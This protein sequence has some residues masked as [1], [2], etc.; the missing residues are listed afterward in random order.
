VIFLEVAEEDQTT[1]ELRDLLAK[2]GVKV[3]GSKLEE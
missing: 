3:D 2:L 1:S